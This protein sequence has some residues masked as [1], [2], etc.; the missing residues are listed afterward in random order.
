MNYIQ[1]FIAG[2]KSL[3]AH[4]L[5]AL[6][7]LLLYAVE[8]EIRWSF[9]RAL[10]AGGSSAFA[11]LAMRVTSSNQAMLWRDVPILTLARALSKQR[12]APPRVVADLRSF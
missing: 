10:S 12:F 8:S 4:G 11:I 2:F 9:L 7:L 5:A 6:V 3:P 1:D